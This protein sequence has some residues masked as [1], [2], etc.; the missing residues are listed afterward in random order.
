MLVSDALRPGSY[1]ELLD[2]V[3]AGESLEPFLAS[4]ATLS[5]L[6]TLAFRAYTLEPQFSE[7]LGLTRPQASELAPKLEGA[8]E[9]AMG[10]AEDRDLQEE[11]EE[12]L[13]WLQACSRWS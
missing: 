8:L 6:A 11:L 9:R 7:G 12:A 10:L 1:R 5:H 13:Q 3:L 4:Q 2:G